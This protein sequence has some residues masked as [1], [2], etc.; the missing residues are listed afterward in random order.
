MFQKSISQKLFCFASVIPFK[1]LLCLMLVVTGCGKES[2]G[3]A[4]VNTPVAQAKKP[5]LQ[6]TA[7]ASAE[8]KK[9][10]GEGRMVGDR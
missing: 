10:G 7:D 6:K 3:P 8:K 1:S 5:E 4:P 2:A 9:N